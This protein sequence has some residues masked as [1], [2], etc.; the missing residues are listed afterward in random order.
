MMS[1]RDDEGVTLPLVALM[2]VVIL[3]MASLVIDLGNGW[4]IRRAL[5][6]AT[7]SAALA[8]AQDYAQGINGC[9]PVAGSAQSYVTSNESGATMVSCQ[10]QPGSGSNGYVTVTASHPV[11]TW[12]ASVLGLGNYTVTS[13]S[14][15]AWSDPSGA[16]GLRPLGL[17]IDGNQD[18][19]DA[20][21]ANPPPTSPVSVYVEWTKEQPTA[22]GDTTGNWGAVDLDGVVGGGAN[23]L[24]DWMEFGYEGLVEFEDH[25]VSTCS[26]EPH[27]LPSQTGS[28]LAST[29]Q[30]MNDLV[31]SGQYFTVPLFNFVENNGQAWYHIIGLARVRL[32]DFKMEGAEAN[33]FI[34]LLVEPGFVPGVPG[35][36]GS[37]T[38]GNKVISIC[39]VDATNTAG[40]L[41]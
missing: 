24:S 35:G 8:A 37:G 4:R 11:Q 31:T 5:I 39:A 40:C 13:A 26:G 27:C 12:F 41:P 2:L 7:D 3:G 30:E 15:A 28:S 14:T 29:K 6:P 36:S 16:Y 25:T 20:I 23:D 9:D 32:V 38:G 33:R 34:D 19:H 21:Y 18:L 1:L 22:C 10:P 17:C